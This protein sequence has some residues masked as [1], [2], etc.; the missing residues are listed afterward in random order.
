MTRAAQEL[1]TMTHNNASDARANVNPIHKNGGANRRWWE[2]GDAGDNKQQPA[3]DGAG[4]STP[5]P[6]PLRRPS[7][8]VQQTIDYETQ[9]REE[10]P[11]ARGRN[12]GS[13][14]STAQG[15]V[16]SGAAAAASKKRWWESPDNPSSAPSAGN[17]QPDPAPAGRAR[18][19]AFHPEAPQPGA[20]SFAPP[21]PSRTAPPARRPAPLNVEEAE[22]LQQ[23]APA[24]GTRPA[25]PMQNDNEDE[26]PTSAPR[27]P[28]R[29]GGLF[30]KPKAAPVAEF[31]EDDDD[32]APVAPP[33]PQSRMGGLFGKGKPEPHV[34]DEDDD[35]DLLE[36]DVQPRI[37]SKKAPAKG[38]GLFGRRA[39]PSAKVASDDDADSIP[40]GPVDMPMP[41]REATE[42][43]K[44]PRAA[45]PNNV[46]AR[47]DNFG[48]VAK[49]KEHKAPVIPAGPPKI[50]F[51]AGDAAKQQ[52]REIAARKRRASM[53]NMKGVWGKILGPVVVLGACAAMVATGF[54]TVSTDKG[55]DVK[56]NW[57]ESA[58]PYVSQA[59]STYTDKVAPGLSTA[60]DRAGTAAEPLVNKISEFF[61]VPTPTPGVNRDGFAKD[62]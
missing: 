37:A 51:D 36:D 57:P 52:K 17:T 12:A 24:R 61:A 50:A 48:A 56:I 23:R 34:A 29:M 19:G 10:L 59:E 43:K 14:G 6:Q 45:R 60:K 18:P 41:S 16:P 2:R 47:G 28:S 25:I 20:E 9:E 22:P 54:V 31:D 4:E 32:E 26:A 53:R 35:D 42:S 27:K 55:F 62:K 44:G 1:A 33:R 5:A 15:Q 30:S 46:F 38:G 58:K 11:S 8:P 40:R 21:P 49:P 3:D 7:A 39:K 13:D